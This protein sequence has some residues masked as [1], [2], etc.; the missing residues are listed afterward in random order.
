M[1]LLP[2]CLLHTWLQRI[3]VLTFPLNDVNLFLWHC[4]FN[5]RII[6]VL[7]LW[8]LLFFTYSGWQDE[9]FRK[10]LMHKWVSTD[11][12]FISVH[13]NTWHTFWCIGISFEAKALNK[14]MLCC[15]RICTY[16]YT[17]ICSQLKVSWV[18]KA[19]FM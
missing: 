18:K 3:N 14:S 15:I 2:A 4:R 1:P 5:S 8:I 6:L 9:E 17:H 11:Y 19:Y 10:V 7:M 13:H 12:F 16:Q